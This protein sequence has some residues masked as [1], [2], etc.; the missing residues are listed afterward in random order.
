MDLG[1][2]HNLNTKEFQE[3]FLGVKVAGACVWQPYHLHVSVFLKYGLT[4]ILEILGPLQAYDGIALTY[5]YT[6]G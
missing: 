4:N 2:S 5:V 3:Y 6:K 1:S